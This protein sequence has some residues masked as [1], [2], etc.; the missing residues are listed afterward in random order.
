MAY[1]SL[2]SG[3]GSN[4]GFFVDLIRPNP[5][6]KSGM[7][8]VMGGVKM[9]E[10]KTNEPVITAEELVKRHLLIV[11][12][13]WSGKTTSTLS[14]L[15]DLQQSNQTTIVFDPTGEYSKLPNTIT[16]RFGDNAYLDAGQLSIDELVGLLNLADLSTTT[17]QALQEA[18]TA[19]RYQANIANQAQPYRFINRPVKEWQA[20]MRQLGHWSGHYAIDLLADQL[21]ECL[22]EPATD[23]P[24][25]YQLMG[26][27]YAKERLQ[28]NWPL[29]TTLRTQLGETVFQ[30][31]FATQPGKQLQYELNFVLQ[32]FLKHP[33]HHRTLVIDLSLLK[34]LPVSQQVVLSVLFKQILQYRLSQGAT[35]PVQVVLDEAHRYLPTDERTLPNNGIFQLAREGRKVQAGLILTTQSPLDLPASLRSQFAH[36]LIH[37]LGS[38][39]EWSSLLGDC[40]YQTLPTGQAIIHG[41][42]QQIEERQVQLPTWW[43]KEDK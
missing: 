25:N 39:E 18:I 26:Q 29:I 38:A 32:M 36:Q 11:G 20:A 10:T 37:H 9:F 17:K 40:P 8:N 15:S 30:E 16:Y 2:H 27:G 43:E 24:A 5:V 33:S 42:H 35:F 28:D 6:I 41:L 3:A 7:I 21:I 31:L 23:G 4:P 1:R 12:Q 13:T 19:L 14:L 34:N 22:V